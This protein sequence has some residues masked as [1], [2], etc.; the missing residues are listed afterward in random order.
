VEDDDLLEAEETISEA[1]EVLNSL[2][3]FEGQQPEHDWDPKI[4]QAMHHMSGDLYIQ[5]LLLQGTMAQRKLDAFSMVNH[6]VLFRN[7]DSQREAAGLE[8]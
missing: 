6:W 8:V 2:W 7:S 4:R 1:I 3:I 5:K